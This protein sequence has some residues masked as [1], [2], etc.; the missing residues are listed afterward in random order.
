VGDL[1]DSLETVIACVA[2]RLLVLT[3]RA[4]CVLLILTCV[5]CCV[6]VIIYCAVFLDLVV[7]IVAVNVH[8]FSV[9]KIVYCVCAVYIQRSICGCEGNM[10]RGLFPA[11]LVSCEEE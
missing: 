10:M 3:L 9:M 11:Q 6:I 5:I 8:W 2:L 4:P 1:V 7:K